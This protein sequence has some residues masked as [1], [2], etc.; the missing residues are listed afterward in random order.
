[1]SANKQVAV[2]GHSL[3]PRHLGHIPGAEI[4]VYRSP[5]AKV[6][7]FETNNKFREVL[8]WSHDLTIYIV[9]RR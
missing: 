2:V 8:E 7:N 9:P 1:M 3:V 6:S 5:G 4:R